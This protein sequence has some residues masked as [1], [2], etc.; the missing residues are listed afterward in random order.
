MDGIALLILGIA[1]LVI[2]V[3]AVQTLAGIVR[4]RLQE[5]S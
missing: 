5:L 2:A 3:F 4:G 1:T